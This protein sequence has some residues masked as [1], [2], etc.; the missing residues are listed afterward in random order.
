MKRN[1]PML[2]I[3]TWAVVGLIYFPVFFASWLLHISARLLL[4]ISYYGMLNPRVGRDIFRS[5][6]RWNP[7]L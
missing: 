7:M 4:A 6:F 5:I 3:I 1:R 2:F